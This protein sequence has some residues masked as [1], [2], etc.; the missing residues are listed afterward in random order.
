MFSIVKEWKEYRV[1]LSTLHAWLLA[2]AGE[3]YK[4]CS[5]DSSL[6][7]W[8]DPEPSE[9]IKTA[10]DVAW[11]AIVEV[12]EVA[13]FKLDSDRAAA[14]ED[15]RVGLLTAAFDDLIPA[16]RKILLGLTLSDADKD[17]ILVKF[18]QV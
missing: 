11:D 17:A 2:N 4:G 7:M 15:A 6:T 3:G 16:E 13:K 5:A 18:P 9:E 1:H 12:D 8:F 14:V 10:I